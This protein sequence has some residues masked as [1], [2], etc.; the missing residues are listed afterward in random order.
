VDAVSLDNL[1]LGRKRTESK[2]S[3]WNDQRYFM[4]ESWHCGW[5]IANL[6]VLFNFFGQ[7][8]PVT[9]V[10]IRKKVMIACAILSG[11]VVVQTVAYHIL[12][13]LKFLARSALQS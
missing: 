6:F 10:M 9:M 13:D 2:L 5:L 8:V 4:E 1:G 3:R 11:V 12:W 7:V